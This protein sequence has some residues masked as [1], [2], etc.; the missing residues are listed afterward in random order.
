[1]KRLVLVVGIASTMLGLLVLLS[2][3]SVQGLTVTVSW[4][5]DT[6]NTVVRNQPGLRGVLLLLL[7]ISLCLS[8]LIEESDGS[9]R[10]E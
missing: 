4:S 1:M 8:P 9:W 2:P 6:V 3:G 10:S 5:I 7:G